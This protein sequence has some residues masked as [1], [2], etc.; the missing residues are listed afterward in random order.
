MLTTLLYSLLGF[1]VGLVIN[2]AA[3]NLPPPAR[4]SILDTPRCSYCG[5][6]RKAWE[7]IGVLGFLFFRGRCSNCHSPLPLRAP[8]VEIASTLLFAFLGNRFGSNFAALSYGLLTAILLLITVTDL[9]H[10]LILNVVVLPGTLIA[11]LLS[12]IVQNQGTFV[13]SVLRAILGAAVGYIFVFG[14]YLLGSLF[15]RLMARAR[16]RAIDE[17]AFGLGDVKLAGLVGAIVG[18]PGIFSVLV[19]TI[20]LGGVVS[21]FVVIFQ[22]IVRRRYSAFMAIPYGPFFTITA[23]ALM[24]WG[25]ELGVG[26]L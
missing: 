26:L 23:W 5:T 7:Q 16:G 17:V 2:R 14:I 24:I 6:T 10:R 8:I 19:Y 20:L 9:E 21:F 4:R 25:R 3:D 22:L 18:F 1:L 11:F 15:A 12:P 13:P